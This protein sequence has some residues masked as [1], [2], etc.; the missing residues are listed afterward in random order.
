MWAR[1]ACDARPEHWPPGF[2]PKTTDEAPRSRTEHGLADE[3][4]GF[5]HLR[6]PGLE[7]L[8]VRLRARLL[9]PLHGGQDARLLVRG[10]LALQ[11]LHR[12]HRVRH[13]A[14]ELPDD[15]FLLLLVL[16]RLLALA[17]LVHELA[18]LALA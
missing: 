1:L 15:R 18:Q 16:V 17:R 9:G 10:E 12:T 11:G 7:L 14:V 3:T 4:R 5:L 2:G 6:E 13:Q 8:E